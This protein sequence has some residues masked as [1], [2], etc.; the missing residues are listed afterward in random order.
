MLA[1]VPHLMEIGRWKEALARSDQ[2]LAQA[3]AADDRPGAALAQRSRATALLAGKRFEDA[4]AAWREATAIWEELGD[5][6]REL[7]GLASTG[8]LMLAQNRESAEG[9]ELIDRALERAVEEGSRDPLATAR[10]LHD[11]GHTAI[12]ARHHDS[13]VQLLSAAVAMLEGHA[14]DSVALAESL[15]LL[16]RA[17]ISPRR[18]PALARE[19]L[20]RALE[21]ARR[22]APGT[23]LEAE[24][25]QLLGMLEN[26]HG[27]IAGAHDLWVKTLAVE[28]VVD[29][30]GYE[31]SLTLMSL[32]VSQARLGDLQSAVGSFRRALSIREAIQAAPLEVAGCLNNLGIMEL[33]SGDLGAAEASFERVAEI[34]VEVGDGEVNQAQTLINLAEVAIERWRFDVAR[35]RAEK[36]LT[37]LEE[38]GPTHDAHGK[39]L[40]DLREICYRQGDYEAADSYSSAEVSFF[41][42]HYPDS[43]ELSFALTGAGN[44]AL[45]MGDAEASKS[46][47]L[48]ALRIREEKTPK[49][50]YVA[51]SLQ[52]VAEANIELG[53]LDEAESQLRRG[54]EVLGGDATVGQVAAQIT[55]S[56]GE[57]AFRRGDFEQAETQQRQAI[58]LW[59]QAGRS[60]NPSVVGTLSGLAEAL[61]GLGRSAEA[62][63]AALQSESLRLSYLRTS[64]QT[65]TEKEALAF[66]AASQRA[67]DLALILAVEGRG[68]I[69]EATRRVF[70]AV[71]RSRA[72]VLD[73]VASRN[74]ELWMSADQG[75]ALAVEEYAS[76]RDK[77]ARLVVKGPGED[78][79]LYQT[80]L[81]QARTAK[82]QAERA[83]AKASG[84]F[85]RELAR[86]EAGFDEVAA[87][88]SLE[89][90]LVAYVRFDRLAPPSGDGRPVPGPGKRTP[91]YA[92]FVLPQGV[93][94]P[95]MVPLGEAE[96]IDGLVAELR[97]QIASALLPGPGTGK[98]ETDQYRAVGTRL[99]ERVWDPVARQLGS[100][101][102]VFVV[103]DGALNLVE[104]AALPVGGSRYLL[105]TGPA[106]HYLSAERDALAFDEAPA[107]GGLLA[108][109]DPA[110]DEPSLFAA[111]APGGLEGVEEPYRV[112]SAAAYRGLRSSCAGFA[113][114][115]FQPLPETGA[116]VEDVVHLWQHRQAEGGEVTQEAV[117]LRGAEAS[118]S[119][120]KRLASGTQIVHLATHGFFLGEGCPSA[121]DSATR[122]AAVGIEPALQGESPLLLSGFALAGANH[123]DAAGPDE[124]DGILT[125]EEI[126]ALNL[127][128]VQ[129]AVLS[130]CDTGLGEVRAG[131]GVFGLRRAFQV[132]G[133]RTVIMS[134]WP[135]EEETG[136]Q[137]M[138]AL[139]ENRFARGMSTID[140][141]HEASLQVLRQHRAA[142]LSTHPAHWAGFIA[143]GDWQ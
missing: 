134:L 12:N 132:A 104:F 137:W 103:P 96:E 72:A 51:E 47:Q 119:A 127:T 93:S 2:A 34:Q 111:L 113:S 19:P 33:W 89:G 75:L 105:E 116:E 83:L 87:R 63:D 15:A 59:E 99:R 66:D 18:E 53:K 65:L 6:P 26:V 24:C 123:R 54:L 80:Q 136:R 109:G 21:I 39:A 35:E 4:E 71:I 68:E 43:L 78:P 5:R 42:E 3:Y 27:N 41:E 84:E 58:Q 107:G 102:R 14:P 48:R 95:V 22:V 94:E 7:E 128:K 1:E 20:E 74:R 100:A 85:R 38:H 29:P 16:G 97:R 101:S 110:F 140:A 98:R 60:D 76:T 126:A 115:R 44:I 69:P 50:F 138:K 88:L 129:W 61:C 9:K 122:S 106:I 56:L 121:L 91:S 139:Y 28:D 143:S 49:S 57:V 81:E 135:V 30:A 13:A 55:S 32:G 133:A 8:A 131:E 10:A 108:L 23:A 46:F 70:D 117:S 64:S 52:L 90:A 11:A 73:E 130:A 77:L 92:A 124:E 118:E 86:Q 45:A 120:F 114:M 37:L 142:G 79:G 36:A 82:E 25:L 17:E 141:V 67:L 31:T 112:A 62:F 40:G 125:A